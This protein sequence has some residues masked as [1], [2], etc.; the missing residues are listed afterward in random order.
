MKVIQLI[1]NYESKEEAKKIGSRW[2]SSMCCWYVSLEKYNENK[3]MYKSFRHFAFADTN[4]VSAETMKELNCKWNSI[5]KKWTTDKTTYEKNKLQFDLYR[6]KVLTE[7]TCVYNYVPP[8]VKSDE[9]QL[10]EL[11][12]LMSNDCDEE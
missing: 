9:D 2:D 3:E 5:Y 10:A 7:I 6:L 12:A 11:I 1:V 4:D 8:P